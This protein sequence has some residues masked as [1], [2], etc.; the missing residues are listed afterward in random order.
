MGC[1]RMDHDIGSTA[2]FYL[3]LAWTIED[4]RPL[5]TDYADIYE[6]RSLATLRAMRFGYWFLAL[7]LTIAVPCLTVDFLAI[8]SPNRDMSSVLGLLLS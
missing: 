6:R 3:E 4:G 8:R 2:F 1:G 7:Q 5:S